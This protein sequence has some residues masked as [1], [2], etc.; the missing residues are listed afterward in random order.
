MEYRHAQQQLPVTIKLL[1][2]RKTEYPGTQ[3]PETFEC[4]VQMSDVERGVILMK[5]IWMN[6][7]LKYRGY[8]FF[9]SSFIDGPVQT[10]ILSVRNDPGTPL[11][12]AGFI[13]VIAGV[14][15]LFILRSKATRKA[16]S[17]RAY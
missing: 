17:V 3:M 12:Y 13:I 16:G 4:D 15:T 10:T 9:Q 7:P 5:K 14:V 6:H 8:S 1:D 11:V 2:F